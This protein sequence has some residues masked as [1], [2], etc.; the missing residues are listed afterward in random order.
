MQISL[1]VSLQNLRVFLASIRASDHGDDGGVLEMDFSIWRSMAVSSWLRDS[2]FSV[3]FAGSFCASSNLASNIVESRNSVTFLQYLETALGSELW[4]E[5]ELFAGVFW[6][7]SLVRTSVRSML[8]KS[9]W[10]SESAKS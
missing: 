4:I 7:Q 3:L 8:M 10:W 9:G 6:R 1:S 2:R 5:H